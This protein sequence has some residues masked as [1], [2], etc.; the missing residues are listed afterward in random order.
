M[1][2]KETNPL[3]ADLTLGLNRLYSK[4]RHDIQDVVDALTKAQIKLFEEHEIKLSA[5]VTPCRIVFAGQDEESV[6][7]G[8]INYPKFPVNQP[9]FELAV[10]YIAGHLM[11]MLSQNRLV[12][13]YPEKT[14]MLE[15]SDA[16]DPDIQFAL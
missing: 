1:I 3:K 11:E 12:I 9:D 5:R 2:K 6:T 7:I 15:S 16:M 8:F 13:E 4:V 14:V 10:E